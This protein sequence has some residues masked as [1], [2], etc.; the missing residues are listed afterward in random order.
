MVLNT[1]KNTIFAK[2]HGRAIVMVEICIHPMCSNQT[3]KENKANSY[4][5]FTE[6]HFSRLIMMLE[7]TILARLLAPPE[8]SK[9]KTGKVSRCH[10]SEM[11]P[12]P[13]LLI[14][15]QFVKRRKYQQTVLTRSMQES[16]G[17][18]KNT[19]E[20][21][22]SGG[23]YQSLHF[24]SEKLKVTVSQIAQD[25]H[26]MPS[27]SGAIH[28][29]AE[30]KPTKSTISKYFNKDDPDITH[31][32]QKKRAAL[33]NMNK[34]NDH[35]KKIDSLLCPTSSVGD[36]FALKQTSKKASDSV[37]VEG[38][39]ECMH[40]QVSWVKQLDD[41]VD[42]HGNLVF[43]DVLRSQ[44]EKQ[45]ERFNSKEKD[46]KA[47]VSE[48]LNNKSEQREGQ[49]P[50]AEQL[51]KKVD[52]Q[53]NLESQR[54]VSSQEGKEECDSSNV[55]TCV[56]D[57]NVDCTSFVT[58][59]YDI[60]SNTSPKNDELNTTDIQEDKTVKG[61]N[62]HET[63]IKDKEDNTK[64]S[65]STTSKLKRQRSNCQSD[66]EDSDS[67]PSLRSRLAKKKFLKTQKIIHAIETRDKKKESDV[68]SVQIGE[69]NDFETPRPR[70]NVEKRKGSDLSD[71]QDL[72]SVSSMCNQTN[73]KEG[74]CAKKRKTGKANASADKANRKTSKPAEKKISKRQV[75]TT[76]KTTSAILEDFS[77][78]PG[79]SPLE[80]I[81]IEDK[82]QVV[83]NVSTIEDLT[84]DQTEQL[85]WECA[86]ELREIFEGKK[87]C[88]RHED[89]KKGGRMK[90][91]LAFQVQFGQF[92]EEQR[93]KIMGVL[94]AMFCYKHSK[95]FDYVSKVLLPETLV[96]LYMKVV[97]RT[98]DEAELSLL[99]RT[100]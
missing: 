89:Y 87:Y 62:H 27:V 10:N 84:A 97:G 93:D 11:L 65:E 3:C 37:D 76:S 7:D 15:Y 19:V 78:E 71:D 74:L 45:G 52:I 50:C 13:E 94:T 91:D 33:K 34:K 18:R 83:I 40:E 58:Y 72:S 23:A 96:M 90:G 77:E 43:Q 55:S 22:Y 48:G 26:L 30:G 99:E 68:D 41:E 12:D 2:V 86:S 51:D 69:D 85:V 80:P 35:Q 100:K 8:T 79:S 32:T 28:N 63:V 21:E 42:I 31:S 38:D 75:K 70:R 5:W 54:A 9:K 17:K 56:E 24:F 53:D 59:S 67:I 44:E 49:M 73:V 92:S 88:R 29:S 20:S 16:H 98:R 47:N 14:Q 66:S 39:S 36:E 64:T 81:T 57:R 1:K 61:I 82:P 95:Y 46:D 6:E 25:L 60:A 4:K